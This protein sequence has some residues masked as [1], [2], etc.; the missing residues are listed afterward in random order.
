MQFTPNTLVRRTFHLL[1]YAHLSLLSKLT[2]IC[3]AALF[4]PALQK[5]RRF[6]YPT[7]NRYQAGNSNFLP[8][9]SFAKTIVVD[10]V[11]L[12]P[13]SLTPTFMLDLRAFY[14]R[15]YADRFFTAQAPSWFLVYM[16]MEAGIHIPVSLWA[17]GGLWRG[18]LW[19]KVFFL[20][21][22]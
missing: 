20:F 4:F 10:L 1:V 11:S 15:T 19:P 3:L 8:S 22:F 14:I 13:L 7:P 6:L 2:D 12:Y 17:V 21:L 16:W 9:V 5:P 18:T